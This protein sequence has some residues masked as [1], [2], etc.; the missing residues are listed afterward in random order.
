MSDTSK[1]LDDVEQRLAR[2]EEPGPCGDG[3]AFVQA[4]EPFHSALYCERC[5]LVQ[6]FGDGRRVGFQGGGPA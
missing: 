1:R 6:T 3:H 4:R 2:L 5:G